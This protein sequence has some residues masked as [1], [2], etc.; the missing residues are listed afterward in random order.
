MIQLEKVLKEIFKNLGVNKRNQLING[1]SP[2]GEEGRNS[3]YIFLAETAVEG[4]GGGHPKTCLSN[5]FAAQTFA[6]S[7]S[8]GPTFETL[9]AYLGRSYF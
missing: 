9:I 6:K 4:V 3:D 5:Y 7:I 2:K 1:Q 8:Y